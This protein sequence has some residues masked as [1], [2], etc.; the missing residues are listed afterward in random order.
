MQIEEAVLLFGPRANGAPFALTFREDVIEVDVSCFELRELAASH[1]R[2]DRDGVRR[3]A[4]VRA[5]R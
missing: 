5:A 4:A 2:V 3:R 1:A